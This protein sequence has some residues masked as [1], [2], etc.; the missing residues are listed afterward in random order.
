MVS[1]GQCPACG[2]LTGAHLRGCSQGAAA[3]HALGGRKRRRS[4]D[5]WRRFEAN[6]LAVESG[7]CGRCGALGMLPWFDCHHRV[8]V[9]LGL[10]RGWGWD[11]ID[12]ESNLVVLCR[13]CHGWVH[14]GVNFDA[15]VADGFLINF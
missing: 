1:S 10:S 15:A 11:E 13:G 8:T 6:G 3:G 5:D 4:S 7:G 2:S 12:D 14:A 9:Q